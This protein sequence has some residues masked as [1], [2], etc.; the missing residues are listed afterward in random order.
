MKGEF[1]LRDLLRSIDIDDSDGTVLRRLTPTGSIQGVVAH[2]ADLY[3]NY[4]VQLKQAK[5]I[6][7][8]A[9]Q[10]GFRT[11]FLEGA[12]GQGDVAIFGELPRLFRR[13]FSFALLRKAFL[14]G[15]EYVAANRPDVEFDLWGVDDPDKYVRNFEPAT[16]LQLVKA[17]ALAAAEWLKTHLWQTYRPYTSQAL[18]DLLNSMETFNGEFAGMTEATFLQ[19][20]ALKAT[21]HC[22]AVPQVIRR[23]MVRYGIMP[24]EVLMRSDPRWSESVRTLSDADLKVHIKTLCNV[25]ADAICKSHGPNTPYS[26]DR[27]FFNLYR[28]AELAIA[29]FQLALTPADARLLFT[30]DIKLKE[31]D[32]SAVYSPRGL[33]GAIAENLRRY[34][35]GSVH[36]LNS[37]LPRD[38]E[39]L[40]LPTQVNVIYENWEL[41]LR[42]YQMAAWRSA[43]MADNVA[44]EMKRRGID[45]AMMV[46][47]GFHSDKIVQMLRDDHSIASVEIV[48]RVNELDKTAYE[49]RMLEGRYQKETASLL[50][51]L[52]AVVAMARVRHLATLWRAFR[53]GCSIIGYKAVMTITGMHIAITRP[54]YIS[55][56]RSVEKRMLDDLKLRGNEVV[57]EIECLGTALNWRVQRGS[58]LY[59]ELSKRLT[60]G[61]VVATDMFV[62]DR[63]HVED[64]VPNSSLVLDWARRQGNRDRIEVMSVNPRWLSFQA[65]VF[66]AIVSSSFH[67]ISRTTDKRRVIAEMRRTLKPGGV[68]LLYGY[69]SANLSAQ[70]LLQGGFENVHC[71]H[72][73][74]WLGIGQIIIARTDESTSPLEGEVDGLRR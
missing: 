17:D 52:S 20:L 42:F 22:V 14:T 43:K 24:S 23:R 5:I 50:P 8:L 10:Y 71:I 64:F 72:G 3:G 2:I 15:S 49:E 68:V 70:L 51:T 46:T 47:G 66:D 32:E 58:S 12:A 67:H 38:V 39:P 18:Q 35:E 21:M 9:R 54:L 62:Y 56:R 53:A 28:L 31:N 36:Q 48:P 4:G 73:M 57:L 60:T 74:P 26:I 33:S 11:M 27:S 30:F 63:G 1:R 34:V 37:R 16:T 69:R 55:F 45:R 25:I 41:P 44:G 29:A 65:R 7:R 6:E 59:L 61:F 40:T 13:A 19:L